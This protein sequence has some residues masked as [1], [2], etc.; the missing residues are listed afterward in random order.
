MGWYPGFDGRAASQQGFIAFTKIDT[1]ASGDLPLGW[2][3]K[4]KMS[5]IRPPPAPRIAGAL[6]G[7]NITQ[8]WKGQELRRQDQ[9]HKSEGPSEK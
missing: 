8:G 5:Q 4:T 9:A 6:Q 1:E 7:K 3:L 2:T